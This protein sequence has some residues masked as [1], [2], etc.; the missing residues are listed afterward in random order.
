MARGWCGFPVASLS[1][2]LAGRQEGRSEEECVREGEGLH[3]WKRASG[4]G[5]GAGVA[6]VGDMPPSGAGCASQFLSIAHFL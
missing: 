2:E 3:T 1:Y 6:S 5:K 4:G